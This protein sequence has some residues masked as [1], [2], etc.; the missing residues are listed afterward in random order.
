M[1]HA[2]A[3]SAGTVAVPYG[4]SS[5]VTVE[6]LAVPAGSY[7]VWATGQANQLMGSDDYATCTLSGNGTIATQAMKPNSDMVAGYAL[8]GVTT[9]PSGGTIT[10]SC[11]GDYSSSYGPLVENNSL[12]AIQVNAIN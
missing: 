7:V 4:F 10:L 12:D 11:I 5:P 3:T 2:F 9:M 8:T 1:S 6:S